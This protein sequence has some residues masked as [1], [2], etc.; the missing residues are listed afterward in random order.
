[1]TPSY[2]LSASAQTRPGPFL[3]GCRTAGLGCSARVSRVRG[4]SYVASDPSCH[5]PSLVLS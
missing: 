2:I 3:R 4:G 1:M 5:G